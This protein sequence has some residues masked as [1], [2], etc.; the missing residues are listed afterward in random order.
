AP[1]FIEDGTAVVLDADV[2]VSDA[3]LDALNSG[4]GDY[5]GASVTLG[6]GE[7]LTSSLGT[8][9]TNEDLTS[10]LTSPAGTKNIYSWY[11]DGN[12][13]Q[14][15]NMPFEGGSD[16]SSTKDYS[17]SGND[18]TVN[19]ATWNLT[20]GHDG[21]G[22]YEFDGNNDYIDLG[23]DASLYP[24]SAITVSAW[25]KGS[26]TQN[27]DWPQIVTSG[28]TTGFNLYMW[29]PT[30]LGSASFIV[31]ESSGSW[32]DCWAK[33][34]VN[35]KDDAWHHLVGVY[36]GTEIQI[37]VD[38]VLEGTDTGNNDGIS[39]DV[40]PP[41]VLIGQKTSSNYFNGAI[42]D[43]QIL[44]IALTAEQIANL[45]NGNE[46]IIDSEETTDGEEWQSK[47]TPNNGTVDE[48]EVES[49][50]VTIGSGATGNVTNADDVFS[51]SD[52]NGITLETSTSLNKTVLQKSG[53]TIAIFDTTTIPGEL[54]ITF[55]NSGGQTPTSADVDYIL[56]QITYANSSDAPP[57]SAQIDWTFDDGNTGS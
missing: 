32:G 57:A 3:E 10:N 41:N 36:N 26:S 7:V 21:K 17:D 29:D 22:A 54:K 25:V 47:V 16:G 5:D 23:N 31:K 51:F 48:A 9:T 27:H 42:D 2:N 19:G 28:H 38:G 34:N 53:A 1:T 15:L 14:V 46:N 33:S 49:N 35:I 37:Y 11:K 44:D 24:T 6:R 52:G 18:G 30:N 43:V 20:G 56:Q 40:T 50:I 39:Y 45:Y 13:I 8:N 55:T 4:N 12:P